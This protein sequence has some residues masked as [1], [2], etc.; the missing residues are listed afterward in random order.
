M[1]IW[2]WCLGT[3][4]LLCPCAP[5]RPGHYRDYYIL[6]HDGD[7]VAKGVKA[8]PGEVS[9]QQIQVTVLW[10]CTV[11]SFFIGMYGNRCSQISLTERQSLLAW[12]SWIGKGMAHDFKVR[13]E[14][15]KMLLGLTTV[16]Q[17]Q[18]ICWGF[19]WCGERKNSKDGSP[20]I[21]APMATNSIPENPRNRADC[22]S[23]CQP[24]IF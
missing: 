22:S 20:G 2:L 13:L 21:W 10:K 1:H 23:L 15:E 5:S 17:P 6:Q 8:L 18:N 11:M 24:S 14:W 19:S 3:H 12:Q 4:V 7:L 9:S 16:H